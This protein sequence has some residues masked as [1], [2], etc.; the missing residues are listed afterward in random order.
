MDDL[1]SRNITIETIWNLYNRYGNNGIDFGVEDTKA[2]NRF[3]SMLQR[4]IEMQDTAYDV[5]KVCEKL[6]EMS[7][8]EER[9]PMDPFGDIDTKV[10]TL[11]TAKLIV[12]AGEDNG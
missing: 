7:Y 11:S 10:V 4:E 5:D 1:I 3:C 2:I 12:K 8:V 9:N 6:N